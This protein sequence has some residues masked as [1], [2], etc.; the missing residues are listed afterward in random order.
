MKKNIFVNVLIILTG[1][2]SAF[3]LEAKISG[4]RGGVDV[5]LENIGSGLCIAGMLIS[6]AIFNSKKSKPD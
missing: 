4:H 2:V 1:I 6:L 5:S 3:A